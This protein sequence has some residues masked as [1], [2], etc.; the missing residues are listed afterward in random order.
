M[1]IQMTMLILSK[2][3]PNPISNSYPN[4]YFTPIPIPIM[5]Q[6]MRTFRTVTLKDSKLN[7]NQYLL[8]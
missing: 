3:Y 6:N 2:C 4:L 7:M 1:L 5:I 8:R